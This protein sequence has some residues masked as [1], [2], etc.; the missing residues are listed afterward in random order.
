VVGREKEEEWADIN[1]NIGSEVET[2]QGCGSN[3]RMDCS[4]VLTPISPVSLTHESMELCQRLGTENYVLS[5]DTCNP[6][7]SMHPGLREKI[8]K[9]LMEKPE[10]QKQKSQYINCSF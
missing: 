6:I 2:Q 4:P 10:K 8:F 9:Y 1:G 3:K 7:S 5:R